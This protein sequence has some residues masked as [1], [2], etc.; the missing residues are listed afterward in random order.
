MDID[1]LNGQKGVCRNCGQR[2]HWAAECPKRG[3]NGHGGKGENGK[4]QGKKG[5]SGKG[6]TD[7]G[8]EKGKGKG[9]KRQA[10]KTCKGYCNHC[11]KWGHMDKDCFTKAKANGKRKSAGSLDE[12]ETCT[13]KHL[14]W[15]IWF[16]PVWKQSI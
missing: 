4:G 9:D 3:N 7:D 14:S 13:R 16:V 10:R 5:K 1:S 11:W 12:S 8:K 2:G 15:R 6:K